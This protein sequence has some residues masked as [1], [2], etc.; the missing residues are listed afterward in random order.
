MLND[1]KVGLGGPSTLSVSI[2]WGVKDVK[3]ENMKAWDASDMGELVWDDEFT[4]AP[5][6]N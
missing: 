3:R 2:T 1:F 6:E 5:A 4:V